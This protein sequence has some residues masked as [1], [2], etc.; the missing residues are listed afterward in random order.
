MPSL[1][2]FSWWLMAFP[3]PQ[4]PN[5]I[6]KQP[7]ELLDSMSDWCKEHH[8]KVTL[9]NNKSAA[10]GISHKLVA[11]TSE[12][13]ALGGWCYERVRG[14]WLGKPGQLLARSLFIFGTSRDHL[15]PNVLFFSLLH[16]VCRECI[17]EFQVLLK[18]VLWIR[19]DLD[20]QRRT[21]RDSSL[22]LWAPS[23]PLS[24]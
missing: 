14:R 17:A 3:R 18:S 22:G 8:G 1:C 21:A 10:L 13:C 19:L 24:S 20:P 15:L 6:I 23:L 7:D 5:L 2:W 4:G 12:S 11:P 9:P 16:S